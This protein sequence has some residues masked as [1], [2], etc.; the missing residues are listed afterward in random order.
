VY[1]GGAAAAAGGHQEDAEEENERVGLQ[2]DC[3]VDD[4]D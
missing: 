4:G 1:R 3:G 2:A